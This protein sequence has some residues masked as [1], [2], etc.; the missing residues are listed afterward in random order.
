MLH[1]FH[2]RSTCQ[3]S[4]K[5]TTELEGFCASCLLTT[6]LQLI[7]CCSIAVHKLTNLKKSFTERSFEARLATRYCA[8]VHHTGIDL[9][10]FF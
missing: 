9:N 2:F 8:Y 5:M 4:L 10:L 6:Q 3:I 1:I 7:W